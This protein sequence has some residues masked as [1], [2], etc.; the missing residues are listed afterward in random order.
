MF[1]VLEAAAALGV[2]AWYGSSLYVGGRLL[3]SGIRDGNPHARW[4]GTY[5]FF[6]MGMASILYSIAMARTTLSGAPMTSLDRV[7]VALHCFAAVIANFAL[8]TFTRR[9]FR[10]ESRTAGLAA[11]AILG[12]LVIGS[13]GH[14]LT[15]GFDGSLTSVYAAIYLA[16]PVLANAWTAGESLLYYRLM[17]KRVAVGLAEPLASNRFLLWGVGA[18]SAAFLLFVNAVQMQL[19]HQ[20]GTTPSL[21][22]RASSLVLLAVLGLVCAVCYLA[23]FFPPRWYVARFAAR[24]SEA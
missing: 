14:G 23:A 5:L 2:L 22:V 3:R 19:N 17:R 10:R 11:A 16:G 1:A 12:M 20:L 4:I 21:P 24:S 6:A 8:L 7:L 15:T 9:V 18:G 13:L